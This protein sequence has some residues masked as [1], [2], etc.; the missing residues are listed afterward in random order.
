MT[1]TAS[2]RD[3]FTSPL[4]ADN[5]I[6]GIPINCINFGCESQYGDILAAWQ[7]SALSKSFVSSVLMC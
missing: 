5:L 6:K 4:Y 3:P 7:R 2:I 1:A